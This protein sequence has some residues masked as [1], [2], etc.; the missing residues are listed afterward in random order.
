M[1]DRLLAEGIYVRAFSFPVVPRGKARIRTQMSAAHSRADLDRAIAAFEKVRATGL[2]DQPSQ[3]IRYRQP[4]PERLTTCTAGPARTSAVG[5]VCTTRGAWE[6]AAALI[7]DRAIRR[8][9]SGVR[10]SAVGGA[11]TARPAK[12]SSRL[13]IMDE[14]GVLEEAFPAPPGKP[15]RGSPRL[16]TAAGVAAPGAKRARTRSSGCPAG[17][18]M[19]AFWRARRCWPTRCRTTWR[20]YTLDPASRLITS[21]FQEG[22][23]RVST[24]WAAQE[25]T[26]DDVNHLADVARTPSGISTLHEAT[27]GDPSSS[28]RWHANMAYGGDQEMVAAL[29]T[30]AGEVWGA[31][32]LISGTRSAD[33]RRRRALAFIQAISQSHG[34]WRTPGAAGRGGGG[35]GRTGGAG[36][37]RAGPGLA[38][39]VALGRS[40][41]LVG[42]TA[43]GDQAQAGCQPSVLAVAGRAL[44]GRDARTARRGRPGPGTDPIRSMG[45]PA[46]HSMAAAGPRRVAVIVEPAHPAKIS[47]L[48]MSAYGLTE[49]EQEVS[50]LV[51]QGYS[52]T[53]IAE[54]LV[55]SHTPCS[56]TCA[57]SSTRPAYAAARSVS[58][59]FFTHYEPR[60]RDNE[61]RLAADRPFRGGPAPIEGQG[62]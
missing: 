59:I 17:L 48:L 5:P 3:L 56:S 22:L 27:N 4:P 20:C 25:Y 62:T 26:G 49:R 51:L 53:E 40:R 36:P 24:G 12:S 9:M 38:S 32:G 54:R 60:L 57:T 7:P 55:I 47:P 18:D 34:R 28:P 10:A 11:H 13:L 14:E 21:H 37:D 15:R 30:R 16:R 58:K 33:V 29:R 44:R 8:A 6:I 61:E 41:G 1:A 2:C 50:R 31:I 23:P 42:R 39:G 43:D 19:V 45:D 35:P 52:T 46:R